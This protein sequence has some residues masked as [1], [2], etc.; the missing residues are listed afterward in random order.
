MVTPTPEEEQELDATKAP[1]LDHL[2]ELRNRIIKSLIA[3][4]IAFLFCYYFANDIYNFL[5]QPLADAMRGQPNRHLIFTALYEKFFTNVKVAA[6]GGICV[7]FPYIA[8]QLWA[9]IAPGLYKH[10]KNAFLPFLMATPVMFIIGAAFVYYGMMPLAIKFFLSFQ[11]TGA[12][13]TMPIELEAK[14]SDYLSFV[15][16]LIFGFGLCFQLPVLLTLLGRVGIITSKQL[17][18]YWR[19]AML[20]VTVLAALFAPPDAA[21]M[22]SRVYDGEEA[23]PP[24]SRG[25]RGRSGCPSGSEET[26]QRRDADIATGPMRF[27][28]APRGSARNAAT[29]GR[30]S[31]CW[32]RARCASVRPRPCARCSW[33]S[34]SDG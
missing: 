21:S 1:L 29:P 10:E 34:P 14:V 32:R 26:R 19:Y 13:G 23:Q 11:N 9:F 18:G 4:L 22:L 33:K 8:A 17:F 3:F 31:S 24:G 15:T 30:S 6:F 5:V 25:G 2:V 12:N 20:G 7:G 28:R 27:A 16:T